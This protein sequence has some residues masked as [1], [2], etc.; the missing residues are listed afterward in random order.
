[1]LELKF[2]IGSLQCIFEEFLNN[3][4]I[5]HSVSK[6]SC[7]QFYNEVQIILEFGLSGLKLTGEFVYISMR[8]AVNFMHAFVLTEQFDHSF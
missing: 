7:K 6:K 1:M 8:R 2:Y 4:N 3:L 5:K